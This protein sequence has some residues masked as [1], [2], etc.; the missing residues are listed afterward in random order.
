MNIIYFHTHDMGRYIGAYGHAVPTP[1]MDRFCRQGTLF[2]KA[3]CAA[4]TCSPSRASLLTG[5]SAHAT[6]M[7]GLLHRGFQLKHPERHLAK[8][9][10]D[11]GYETALAGVQHE[12]R[13]TEHVE[14]C[15]EHHFPSGGS[16]SERDLEAGRAAVDF[17][18]RPHDRPFFLSLGCFYPHR[19]FRDHREAGIN[20]DYVLPPAAL[21]DTSVI[22]ADM[23][24]YLA[25]VQVA[26]EVFGM[27]IETLE[28]SGLRDE[29]LIVLTTDHG[30]PFPFMKCNLTDYGIGVTL[31]LDIP[32]RGTALRGRCADA[33]VSHLDVCP[34][35]YE[36]LGMEAPGWLEGHSLL[37]LMEG[38]TE[39][40]RDELFAEVS[41]H[42]GYE[43]TRCIRTD[44]YKYIEVYD[45]DPGLSLPNVENG[46]SKEYFL[47]R[48][49]AERERAEAYL[50]DLL[51]DPNEGSN[52]IADPAHAEV[53]NDLKARLR[54][55]QEATN[56][57][58]LHYERIPTPK[59]AKINPKQCPKANEKDFEPTVAD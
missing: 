30:V 36:A 3:F 14:L 51:Y 8:Q 2:R 18:R 7:L 44:R 25:S 9:L 54:R 26:D 43:G 12:L 32:G 22:R 49:L 39:T 50:Y 19:K 17:L 28:Q 42:A 1:H 20:P 40:V 48:G 29:T 35:L 45:T 6:G 47:E 10:R 59:D 58:A 52:L 41:F 23:A 27:M 11:R 33:M 34:T 24:D 37:P 15:Y 53:A 46:S 16:G 5:Q 31:A 55:W 4:P 13:G 56:D 38:E 57:P 21:P